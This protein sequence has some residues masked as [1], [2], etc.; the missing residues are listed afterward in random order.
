MREAR[1]IRNEIN[2]VKIFENESFVVDTIAFDN[3]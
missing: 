2:G 1:V 3:V